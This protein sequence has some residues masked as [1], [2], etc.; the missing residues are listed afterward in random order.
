MICCGMKKE[1]KECETEVSTE[2]ANTAFAATYGSG[3]GSTN[4]T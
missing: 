2:Q 3:Q 1:A 4:G